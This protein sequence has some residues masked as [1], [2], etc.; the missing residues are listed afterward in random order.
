MLVTLT[1]V[2]HTDRLRR[3]PVPSLYMLDKKTVGNAS[4]FPQLGEGTVVRYSRE[5]IF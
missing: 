4:G 2:K 1:V 5:F 3:D